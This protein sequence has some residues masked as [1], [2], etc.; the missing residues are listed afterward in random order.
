MVC[1]QRKYCKCASLEAT[2]KLGTSK[3]IEHSDEVL[4][5]EISTYVNYI[6]IALLAL[7]ATAPATTGVLSFNI[8]CKL[9]INPQL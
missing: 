3:R 6:N 8:S 7:L 5:K 1:E 4:S 9:G 2:L